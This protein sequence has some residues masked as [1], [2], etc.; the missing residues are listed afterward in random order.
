MFLS[1]RHTGLTGKGANFLGIRFMHL[2][3]RRRN[4]LWTIPSSE[5]LP[6]DDTLIIET[7]R[8]KGPLSRQKWQATD[9]RGLYAELI[10]IGA[11]DVVGAGQGEKRLW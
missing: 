8:L 9:V 7:W 4:P 10:L 1:K 6:L 11:T 2:R 5:L 3:P